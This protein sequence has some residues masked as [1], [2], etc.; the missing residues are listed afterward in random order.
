MVGLKNTIRKRF[1]AAQSDSLLIETIQTES[2]T[3]RQRLRILTLKGTWYANEDNQ[4]V[5]ESLGEKGKREKFTF[6]GSWK[7][8]NNQQ[9][10]YTSKDGRGTLFF[11]G[12]WQIFSANKLVYIFEG[13]S[14]SRFEFKVQLESLTLQPKKGEIRYRIGIGLRRSR[15][16]RP[17]GEVV[18]LYGEWK[19]SRNLGLS[20]KMNYGASKVRAIEFGAEVT[21]DRNQVNLALKNEVGK[22][23]CI[24]LTIT[25]KLFKALDAKAFIRL[26]TCRDEQG[27][28]AGVSIPF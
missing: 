17:S 27:V 26:E 16:A 4:L 20:F 21:F 2:K 7:V 18:I 25:R 14:K 11:K 19:F 28:E 12:Y 8:N 13:S 1:I 9:I 24:T 22:P 15:K 23:L 5:F 3:H 10:E 6:K